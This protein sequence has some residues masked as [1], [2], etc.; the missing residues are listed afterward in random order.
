MAVLFGHT[1]GSFD[2]PAGYVS[3]RAWPLLNLAVDGASAV[4]MFFVLSGFVL[5]RPYLAAS[6][7]MFVPSFYIKRLSRIWLP[8][9]FVFI[10]SLAARHWLMHSY[11]MRPAVSGWLLGFWHQPLSFKD[12]FKQCIF[13]LYDFSR[14]LLPQDWSLGVELRASALMPF[15]LIMARWRWD[16]LWLGI[17]ALVFFV[18]KST[19]GYY[20][21]FIIGVLLARHGGQLV[22]KLK[23]V[24]FTGRLLVL[25]AGV[26]GYEARWASGFLHFSGLFADQVVWVISSFGCAMIIIATLASRRI[27]HF[28]SRRPVLFIGRISYSIYLL[29]FVVLICFLPAWCFYLNQRGV[30]LVGLYLL[31]LAASFILTVSF[32]W[33]MYQIIEKPSIHLGHW[34]AKKWEDAWRSRR[35]RQALSP[36]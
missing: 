30:N 1:L 22:D 2:W 23:Q 9:F 33:V 12:L 6:R 28:L 24:K 13:Q 14:T 19:G 16:W 18:G 17:L 29:Q 21:A 34:L 32:S 27:S 35:E 10:I 31:I 20:V 3:W 25:L 26:C 11:E 4:T 15:F 8:W 5:M 36:L 7:A